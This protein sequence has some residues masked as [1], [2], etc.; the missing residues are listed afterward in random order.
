MLAKPEY[1]VRTRTVEWGQERKRTCTE[2][3]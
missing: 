2:K 3:Q 1:G